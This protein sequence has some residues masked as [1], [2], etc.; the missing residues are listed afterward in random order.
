LLTP[1]LARPQPVGQAPSERAA[2]DYFAAPPVES[3]PI[4]ARSSGRVG[5][6][7]QPTASAAFT[8]TDLEG[9][10]LRNNPALAAAAARIEA[11]RGGWVQAGLFPNPVVGYNSMDVGNRGTAGQQGALFRQQFITAGKLRLGQAVATQEIRQARFLFAAYELR[12]LSD[13][14]MRYYDALTAQRRVEIS[15]ELARI[16]DSLVASTRRLFDNRQVS[17]N[18]LLQA[19]IEAEQAHILLDNS[20]NEHLEAWRRLAAVIGMPMLQLAP[21]IGRLDADPPE[22]GWEDCLSLTLSQSPQLAAAAA[23]IDRARLAVTRA[24]REAVPNVD[25]M[26][27]AFHNNNSGS[28]VASVQIGLPLPIFNRNQGN[29]QR[30]EAESAAAQSDLRRLELDLQDRLAAAYRRYANARQQVGRYTERILPKARQSLDLVSGAYDKG[31]VD[32]LT[33]ITSQRTFLQ[34]N[35]AWIEAQRELWLSLTA[36]EGQLLSDSLADRQ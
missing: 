19:E 15:G 23:R 32:Y 20:R 24:R 11:A 21:L 5:T 7:S 29:V 28:N 35:L 34:V 2:P 13:V 10:A 4:P 17:E 26:V 18:N 25:A 30:A 33:L 31:Q 9:I 12:V 1:A 16:G 14:R 27:S 8:L 22:Y 3:L 6:E 36:I